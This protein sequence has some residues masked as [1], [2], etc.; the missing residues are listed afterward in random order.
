MVTHHEAAQDTA[1]IGLM[2]FVGTIA[3]VMPVLALAQVLAN[4]RDYRYPAVAIAVWLGVLGAAAWLVPRLRRGGLGAAEMAAAVTAAVVA[5]AIIGAVRRPHVN[6]GSVDLAVLGTVWLLALIVLSRSAWV[7]IPGAVLV[8]AVHGGLV[9]RDEGL[10]QVSLSQLMASG[11]I[12]ATILFAFFALRP[13]IDTHVNMA[14]RRATLASRSVAERAA[15]AAIVRER[16]D[17]LAFLEREALPLLRGIASGALDPTADDVRERCA[18]HAAALRH[19]LTHS[20]AADPA[21][22]GDLAAV[23]EPVLGGARARGLRVTVQVIG[24][25]GAPRP[26][27]ARAAAATVDAV[28]SALAPHQVLLTVLAAGDDVEM[29]LTFGTPPRAAPDLTRFGL[30]LPAAARWRAGLV[31]TESGGGC[32]EVSWRKDSAT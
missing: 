2:R 16:H 31:P 22:T 27:V 10:S 8:F 7:W 12:M 14:A 25:P 1:E 19:S 15:A 26:E 3:V 32:L 5:V 24:V 28:L 21:G 4:A 30:D 23:L 13:T 6:P 11:Y 20:P 17:R 9:L 18:R 29:Y